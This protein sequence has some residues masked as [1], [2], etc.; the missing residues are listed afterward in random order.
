M[1]VNHRVLGVSA[2][3]FTILV[4]TLV[5]MA[6]G[7]QG[8]FFFDD[9][10]NIVK[11]DSVHI[12]ELTIF[13]LKSS[14][15]G[16]SAGPLGRPVS[17]LSFALTHYFFGLDPF[18]FKAV[19]LALHCVNG[20]LVAWLVTLLL[21]VL[22]GIQLSVNAKRWL[23]VWVAAIWLIHPINVVPVLLAV[24]RMTLLSGMFMLL[25][26]ICHLKAQS[27]TKEKWVFWICLASS[28]LLFWPLSILSKETGL[29]FPLYL[30][31]I[32][33]FSRSD[34]AEQEKRKSRVI[35]VSAI[36]LLM[37]TITMQS[38]LGW[39]WLEA[40]YGMRS[41]TLTER[42][43]TEARVLWF[44]VAQT[45]IPDHNAFGIYLDDF[46]LST[47]IFYPQ[48]T[49]FALMGWG[50][51]ITGIW[52]F[53]IRYPLLS[54]A[55]AW[56]LVGHSL[57]STFLPLEIVHEYRNYIPSIG[58]ILGAGYMGAVVLQKL[59]LDYR[60]LMIILVFTIPILVLAMFTWMRADQL[61]S[62]LVGSQI[63]ATRHSQSARAN[64]SAALALV[65]YGYGDSGD[66]IGG[67]QIQYYFQQAGAADST[68]KIGYLG[69]IVW[70]CASERGVDK[71]WVDELAF[72]LEHTPLSPRDRDIPSNLLELLL[73]LP[74]C[75]DRADAIRLFVA[76]ASN[77]SSIGP[78]RANFFE[79]A[80]DYELLVSVDPYSAKKHLVKAFAVSPNNAALRRKLKK[81]GPM[82]PTSER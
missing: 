45:L 10:P 47:G 51:V 23:P 15:T 37:I 49:I 52:F 11:N 53:R 39:G 26:L 27:I 74:K 40:G 6:P 16:P 58:L 41:F 21:Q 7:L 48:Q 24:Q 63:E 78:L 76:G 72:R 70:G 77:S 31:V 4:L 32:N 20:L 59:K 43:L 73:E 56:F 35:M 28:W 1:S 71:L 80:S 67:Q 8:E 25:A 17:V 44:Y 57:E 34:S 54:F 75:L 81:F 65:Q 69:L 38:F 29:L 50:G 30:L 22:N 13:S 60:K 36:S 64:Y 79:A 55:V 68:F 3:W 18:A 62:P 66:P 5:V 42:L 2:V 14:I 19:N 33:V 46:V 12:E 9:D 82:L 61:G